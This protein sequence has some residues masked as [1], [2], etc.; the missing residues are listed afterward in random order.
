MRRVP[1]SLR[2]ARPC[3]LLPSL[4]TRGGLVMDNGSQRHA[5]TEAGLDCWDRARV[6]PAAE[7]DGVAPVRSIF[8][9]G[10]LVFRPGFAHIR[11][12]PVCVRGFARRFWQRSCDHRGT[13]EAP[14]RVVTL[15]QAEEAGACAE[16]AEVNGVAYDV[17]DED[18]QAV[19]EA[20]DI[21]E[22][23]G[24]VRTVTELFSPGGVAVGGR[25][26]R[27]VVY[28]AHDPRTSAAYAGPEPLPRTAQV[29]AS[30]RGPSGRNDDYLFSLIAALHDWGLP[31]DPYLEELAEA[32]RAA[33]DLGA[34]TSA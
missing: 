25:L 28:Y 31:P 3:I 32:V 34:G 29:I 10:S 7:F 1:G 12:Y 4:V 11:A 8:G 19:L 23:H 16:A 33:Q 6:D 27:A 26:G 13:P 22:R 24:Y 17:A 2:R 9:Y 30:S 5:A 18:W 14:G 20:L 21:R 15:V